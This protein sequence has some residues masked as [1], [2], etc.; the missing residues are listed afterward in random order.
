MPSKDP[1]QLAAEQLA[2][3]AAAKVSATYEAAHDAAAPGQLDDNVRMSRGRFKSL[4]AEAF[5]A[6]VRHRAHT[7]GVIS[8]VR[9]T[10]AR[11]FSVA[12]LL[13]SSLIAGGAGSLAAAFGY[14]AYLTGAGVLSLSAAYAIL[15]AQRRTVTAA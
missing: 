4:L 8:I 14:N 6:G 1:L 9:H 10:L 3:V 2:K 7:E 13:A 12:G 5:L 11:S 15:S